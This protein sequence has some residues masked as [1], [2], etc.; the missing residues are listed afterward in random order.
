MPQG[1]GGLEQLKAQIQGYQSF[2][3]P[4]P[5]VQGP[6]DWAAQQLGLRPVEAE[7]AVQQGGKIGRPGEMGDIPPKS[8]RLPKHGRSSVGVLA[9]GNLEGMQ[10]PKV[11]ASTPMEKR[12]SVRG[13]GQIRVPWDEPTDRYLWHFSPE[14]TFAGIK[15]SGLDPSL[16]KGFSSGVHF[17]PT[18]DY[19][20]LGDVPMNVYRAERSQVPGLEYREGSD[21]F[22]RQR[23][24]PE[25]LQVATE[26]APGQPTRFSGLNRA[27]SLGSGLSQL[28]SLYNSIAP[29]VG[30]PY[31]QTPMD[32]V[33]ADI[34]NNMPNSPYANNTMLA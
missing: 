22:T 27:Y 34:L 21:Y 6:M 28:G 4:K 26:T 25:M 15:K 29:A 14:E 23:I 13:R 10:V 5:D 17:S 11:K 1:Y 33:L 32:W 7:T 24:P 3:N 9:T 12:M 18:P 8:R 30:L 31:M 20:V 2:R 16:K 19:P